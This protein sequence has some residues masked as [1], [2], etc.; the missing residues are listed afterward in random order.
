MLNTSPEGARRMLNAWFWISMVLTV[1]GTIW[2]EWMRKQQVA[3]SLRVPPVRFPDF[4]NQSNLARWPLCFQPSAPTMILRGSRGYSLNLANTL[5][6]L[7]AVYLAGMAVLI[8][9]L[10]I[11]R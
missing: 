1:V 6:C 7:S 8:V 4:L 11:N 10:R 3:A 2:V 5:T 9:T